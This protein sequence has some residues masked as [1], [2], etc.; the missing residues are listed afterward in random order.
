[1]WTFDGHRLYL[2]G[3]Y[4]ANDAAQVIGILGRG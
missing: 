2:V 4:R 3:H 1:V